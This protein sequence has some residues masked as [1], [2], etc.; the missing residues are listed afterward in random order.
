MSHTFVA[1]EIAVMRSL[2][3]DI[4]TFSVWPT[5]D[6]DLLAPADHREREAT[7]SLLEGSWC[8]LRDF[9]DAHRAALADP[10]AYLRSLVRAVRLGRPGLRGR[11]HALSWF[12]EAILMW[13]RCTLG[14]TTHIHVH[15]RGTAT[16]VAMLACHHADLRG[17]Q[18]LSWSNTVHGPHEFGAIQAERLGEKVRDAKL[19]I[20]ISD[21]A[22]SQLLAVCPES[23]W[24][25]IRVARCGVDPRVFAPL[26][27]CEG[28]ARMRALIVGRFDP[29]KGHAVAFE[30]LGLLRRRGIDVE[31][32]VVGGGEREGE[33]R[34]LAAGAGV[35]D[36]VTWSGPI[37]QDRIR[38]HYA[39]CDVF[40]LPS[41]AEG[42]PIVLMEAMAMRKPVISCAVAG[43]PELIDDGADGLLIRPGRADELAVALESLHD[44]ALRATLGAAARSKVSREYDLDR[45]VAELSA[46]F[47]AN[48]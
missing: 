48:L 29:L 43:I 27:P 46:L 42:I 28:H 6:E 19:T 12:V 9:A 37:G 3:W 16:F 14:G 1:R 21:Y 36:L 10:G 13:R 2:G 25:K 11:L 5:A 26:E 22:R 30:A 24:P 47:E 15:L 20:A 39:R 4:E 8:R 35:D 40:C 32:E 18:R 34:L 44:P 31:L 33:L 41:F 7:Y 45:N 17:G 38:A 23:D